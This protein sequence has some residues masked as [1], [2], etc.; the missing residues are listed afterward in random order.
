M[1]VSRIVPHIRD[2]FR[3]SLCQSLAILFCVLFG[4]ALVLNNQMQGEAFWFW[5]AVLIHGGAKL[6]S[7]LHFVLQPL[8]ILQTDAWMQLFGT[9]T[10]ATEIPSIFELVA[11]CLAM[12]L[13]LRESD[14]P[15]WQKAAMLASAFFISIQCTAYRFDDYHIATDTYIFLSLALLLILARTNQESSPLGLQRQLSLVAAIGILSGFAI[16]TKPNDGGALLVATFLSLPFLA[17]NK[18]LLTLT[19]FLASAVL[20]VIVVVKLTGDSL[21]SY[22]S[23]SVIKAAAAKGGG[24]SILHSPFLLFH[25]ALKSALRVLPHRKKAFLLWLALAGASAYAA[26][27][28]KLKASSIFLAQVAIVFSLCFLSRTIRKMMWSGDL[29]DELANPL[30]VLSYLLAPLVVAHYLWSKFGASRRGWDPREVLLLL[31][32]AELASAS[33]GT[34]GGNVDSFLYAQVAMLLLIV[35]AL[36]PFR[37]PPGWVSASFLTALLLIGTSGMLSKIWN[38]YSWINYRSSPMFVNRLWYRHPV[39]GPMYLDRDLLHFIEPVCRE[40]A[41][42]G[43]KPELLSI[44]FSYPNYFCNTPPWHGYVQT[45]FDTSSRAAINHLMQELDS[46]PPQ[47][48]VYQ[49]QMTALQ[50]Q[51]SVFSHGQPLPHRALDTMI[52]QKI[53]TGQWQ[54]VDTRHYLEG[55]GW[56]IIKTR[57]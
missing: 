18:K 21:S 51:E 25:N 7:D 10:I 41:E 24:G 8:Y 29:V 52:M 55:D 35:P 20:T 22:A 30:I 1:P 48:I 2:A 39:W 56:L 37:K 19:L 46:A 57:P 12:F 34:A 15:D 26:R 49:R 28:R 45:F 42:P 14:W 13:I 5:Y 23:N 3:D 33:A 50:S 27:F 43:G 11:Y 32:L 40:I 9:K 17:R 38:P 4:V 53:A 47:W 54:L 31:P 36:R 16:T 6:Y 44:P